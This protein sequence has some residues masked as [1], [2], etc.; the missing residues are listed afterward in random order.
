MTEIWTAVAELEGVI[1]F[2]VV[3]E[4]GQE[5]RQETRLLSDLPV[6]FA[7][8]GYPPS[9][10]LAMSMQPLPWRF[11]KNGWYIDGLEVEGM[12]ELLDTTTNP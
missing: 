7:L 2:E 9:V 1:T 4:Q 5:K 3:D 6:M 11:R 10:G 12:A 8:G